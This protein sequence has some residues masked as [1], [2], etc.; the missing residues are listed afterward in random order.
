MANQLE[1][2][3]GIA[4]ERGKQMHFSYPPAAVLDADITLD[5]VLEYVIFKVT[6]PPAPE[7]VPC[8]LQSAE[9][10]RE[11][12]GMK[13]VSKILE[14]EDKT[15]R[16][17]ESARALFFAIRHFKS[18]PESY[19][20]FNDYT[21]PFNN[22]TT[23]LGTD[24]KTVYINK[25][26]CFGVLQNLTLNH[27]KI[28][29]MSCA[30]FYMD[31]GHF[32]KQ[33]VKKSNGKL[34]F[35]EFNTELLKKFQK[36][37]D[38]AIL[39][40]ANDED[41]FFATQNL[42]VKQMV[43]M[44]T[45]LEK[46]NPTIWKNKKFSKELQRSNGGMS[47][48]QRTKLFRTFCVHSRI[49]N[50]LKTFVDKR[51]DLFEWNTNAPTVPN[52]VRIFE[53][54]KHQ[55]VFITELENA[56]HQAFPDK[57]QEPEEEN[58]PFYN[59]IGYEKVLE[60]YGNFVEKILFIKVSIP[61][62]TH[63]S[64]YVQ[65]PKREIFCILLIDAFFQILKSLLF[66]KERLFQRLKGA[67]QLD[68]ICEELAKT[69]HPDQKPFCFINV[70]YVKKIESDI[71]N[72][73][74]NKD[75][76]KDKHLHDIRFFGR[77]DFDFCYLKDELDLMD[78]AK[79]FPKIQLF[80]PA[81]QILVASGRSDLIIDSSKN[82]IDMSL[83]GNLT[84]CLPQQKFVA[85]ELSNVY[86]IVEKTVLLCFVFQFETF[87]QFIHT[88]KKCHNLFPLLATC[89]ECRTTN[90]DYVLYRSFQENT[91]AAIFTKSDSTPESVFNEYFN[92]FFDKK[93]D[94]WDFVKLICDGYLSV[95]GYQ[96]VYDQ[97]MKNSKREVEVSLSTSAQID[98]KR[99]S[100]DEKKKDEQ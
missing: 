85:K 32:L 21:L 76:S 68:R 80:A 82:A 43:K 37:V 41:A 79:I 97:V 44:D 27:P 87:R 88:Q 15:C 4:V 98:K 83:V 8:R 51:P 64:T 22:V 92:H 67:D 12:Y 66:G 100:G 19:R 14:T 77:R 57:F 72:L 25:A 69:F 52:T 53:D 49:M 86:E 13:Y 48:S 50:E 31:L 84:K 71:K 10:Q 45:I 99:E 56:L 62:V 2:L 11:N 3:H 9:Q 63:K 26:D 38:L 18:Y 30:Y 23:Y 20:F 17:Y 73:E 54:A 6:G 1:I 34:E 90:P 29:I 65:G 75:L 35:V 96:K 58:G 89:K 16:M 28:E 39:K 91:V 55:F 81:V 94:L 36:K 7:K 74:L 93:S 42:H 59:T 61:R 60:E 24:N 78:L 47:T 70:E 46:L 5:E 40:A 33:L 95:N